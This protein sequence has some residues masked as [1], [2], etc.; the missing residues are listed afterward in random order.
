[1]DPST[2]TW[3]YDP[4]ATRDLVLAHRP[5]AASVVSVVVSDLVWA[6]VVRLL[7]WADAGIRGNDDLAPGTWWR[8]A[9]SCADLLRRLPGLCAEVDQP[10]AVPAT[11]DDAVAPGRARVAVVADRLAGA[12]RSER[13]LALARVA[14]EVD[15]LGA[16]AT[17]ALA[18]DSGWMLPAHP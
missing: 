3:L 4:A 14:A 9:A 10:W 18:E 2:R 8:L 11:D 12:L 13:P 5:A 17:S 6:D 16:A 7:R 1:M 15:A